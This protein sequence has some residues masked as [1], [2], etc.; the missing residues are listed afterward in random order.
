MQRTI[1]FRAIIPE[2]NATIYFDLSDLVHPA[3]KD[4]FSKREIL[5]P[6]LLAGNKPDEYTGLKDKNGVEIY[7]G[8]IVKTTVGRHLWRYLVTTDS[9]F[10]GNNLYLN[11]RY[12]NFRHINVDDDIEWGDFFVNEC[13]DTITEYNANKNLEVI[14]N[15]YKNKELLNGNKNEES[16]L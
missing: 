3:I 12:R 15:I 7:E 14:G 16:T 2:R 9:N 10:G 1:K 5:I 4:L 8:D 11:T 6:W 13:R